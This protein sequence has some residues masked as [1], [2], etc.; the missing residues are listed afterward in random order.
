[1]TAETTASLG[2]ERFILTLVFS[3]ILHGVLLLGVGFA[4]PTP[5]PAMPS[6]DV[7]LVSTATR[8][9]PET[10][11]FLANAHQEGGGDL[12]EK[13]RPTAP[14]SAPVQRPDAGNAQVP[15]PVGAPRAEPERTVP[16][17]ATR[18]PAETRV[19]V[20]PVAEH[21]VEA[22]PESEELNR[23]EQEQ[24]RLAAEIDNATRAYAKRPRRKFISAQ[25][26]EYAYAAYMRAWVA[27]V[28]RVGNLNYPDEARQRQIHGEL[29][30]TVAIERD[31]SIESI[32]IVKSSGERVL[33]DAAIQI[34]RM[35][36]PFTELP[37]DPDERIDILHIT[38]TWQF[39]PG[40]VLRHR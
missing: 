19:P 10:A 23:L 21:P 2:T 15:R 4:A 24:A 28:E 26:R 9:A 33:D 29:I 37:D 39:L 14:D 31:G 16:V 30:L 5:P 34:V 7:I 36:A 32:D 17:L 18:A 1:M 11:D 27:R 40:D 3:A 6:L 8:Q 20:D 12:D 25:T 35:S 13:A 38:R 22:L